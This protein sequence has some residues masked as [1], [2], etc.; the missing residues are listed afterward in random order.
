MTPEDAARQKSRIE[1]FW[2]HWRPILG[3]DEWKTRLDYYEGEFIDQVGEASGMALASTHVR[4]EYRDANIAW[5]LELVAKQSDE[6]LE[7]AVIHEGAHILLNE[8]RER[9]VK[10][11]E[12]AATSIALAFMRSSSRL[13]VEQSERPAHTP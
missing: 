13:S 3:L 11:E 6:S 1:R 10:H 9:S 4:W 5:N 8:M 2:I 12:H 7:E